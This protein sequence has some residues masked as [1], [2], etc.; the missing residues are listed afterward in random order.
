MSA[1]PMTPSPTARLPGNRPDATSGETASIT[2]LRRASGNSRGDVAAEGVEG[3][4]AEAVSRR[5]AGARATASIVPRCTPTMCRPKRTFGL[6]GGGFAD[7]VE[8]ADHGRALIFDVV[9]SGGLGDAARL[10]GP[11][12]QLKPKR[13]GPNCRRLA[14]DLGGVRS[15]E[16][17]S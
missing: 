7:L 5:L 4:G 1:S 6:G 2:A 3:D 14:R 17:T 9:H 11:D 12:V 15:E 13:F 8:R 16:H 10:F